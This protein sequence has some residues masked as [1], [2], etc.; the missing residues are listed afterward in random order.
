MNRFLTVTFD[1]LLGPLQV[2]G[3]AGFVAATALAGGLL[4]LLLFRLLAPR[5]RLRRARGR[6]TGALLAIRL[7]RDTPAATLRGLVLLLAAFPG[8]LKLALPPLAVTLL[9]LLL[10]YVHL[11]GRLDH[12]PLA[13]GERTLVSLVLAPEGGGEEAR[14]EAE[15]GLV[16][17]TPP[18]RMAARREVDWRIRAERKGRFRLAVRLGPRRL[19]KEVAVGAGFVPL[20]PGR[21]L[22]FRDRFI[23]PREEPLPGEA[24]VQSLTIHYPRRDF[25]LLGL[26]LPWPLAWLLLLLGFA[27]LLKSPLGVEI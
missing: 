27:W 20:S 14:I 22:R 4:A 9:P 19:T 5:E 25:T 21:F 24:G 10:L 26:H 17:E 7:F 15:P 6:L 16:V 13:P 18:L 3:P 12:R 11:A 1:H 23:H 8:Y 2:L